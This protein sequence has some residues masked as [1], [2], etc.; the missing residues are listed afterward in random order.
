MDR[1]YK[2]TLDGVEIGTTRFEK[3][4][5]PMGVLIG[6]IEFSNIDSVYDYIKQFSIDNNVRLN[7]DDPE[8]KAIGTD[9]IESLKVYRQDGTEI[10]GQGNVIVGMDGEFYEIHV[11]AYPHMD[12]FPDL[13]EKYENQFK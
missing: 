11:F 8:F 7:L 4:D 2:I 3:A 1:S 13:L 12:E 10:K 6:E 9:T 5:Y